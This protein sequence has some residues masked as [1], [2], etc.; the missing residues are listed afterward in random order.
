MPFI[1]NVRAFAPDLING[2]LPKF[3]TPFSNRL[4][5]HLNSPI[6][7][8]FFDIPVAQREGVI[9]PDAVTDNFA[10]EAVTGVD[11]QGVANGVESG[12]LFYFP[13]N[14]IILVRHNR[15]T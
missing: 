15:T 13:V 8:H 6:Q 9:K 14:L 2:L 5:S 10:R 11:E 4:V 7:H 12:R 1:H 3:L